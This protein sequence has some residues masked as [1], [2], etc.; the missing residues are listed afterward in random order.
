LARRDLTISYMP[1]PAPRPTCMVKPSEHIPNCWWHLAKQE[2]A[3]CTDWLAIPYDVEWKST[4]LR[5]IPP[6]TA[7]C[8]HQLPHL[9][10]KSACSGGP[11]IIK[12]T[13]LESTDHVDS[14]FK[15]TTF[16]AQPIFIF[17]YFSHGSFGPI[18]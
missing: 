7:V 6:H 1:C 11:N 16:L 8:K 12:T 17:F 10:E 18:I 4:V 9:E 2:F 5:S 3:L 13:F 15:V 14:K